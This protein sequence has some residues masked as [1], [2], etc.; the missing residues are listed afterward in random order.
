MGTN[1]KK[2]ANFEKELEPDEEDLARE[3]LRQQKENM[4]E[5]E[6]RRL[7]ECWEQPEFRKMFEDYQEEVSDPKHRAETE[8]YLAQVEAEQRAG[9]AA[10]AQPPGGLSI[11]QM[12]AGGVPGM[13][14]DPSGAPPGQELLK[15][16]KGFAIKTWER[17]P[18]KSDFDREMGK[19]FINVCCHDEIDKPEATSVTDPKTGQQGQSWSMPHLVSPALRDDKC[20]KGHVCKVVDIVFHT[21]VLLR[22]EREG[23]MGAPAW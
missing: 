14:P 1:Y 11:D 13:E 4:S 20:K 21:E 5:K 23:P 18:G 12:G 16:K 2:W 22:A 10:A 7:H 6:V 19:V 15:P 17:Q 8:E 3:R 9:K